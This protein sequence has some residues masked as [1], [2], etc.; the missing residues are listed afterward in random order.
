M[1]TAPKFASLLEDM[2]G[3]KV[4]LPEEFRLPGDRVSVRRVGQAVVLEP[5]R[6][7]EP[8]D[9]ERF[10]EELKRIDAMPGSCMTVEDRNQ[11]PMPPPRDFSKVF[12]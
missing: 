4:A 6:E 1:A 5:V 3:Q 9:R 7:R 10:R 11:P 12:P 8:F 2:D